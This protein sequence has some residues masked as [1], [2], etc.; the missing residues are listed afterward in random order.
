MTTKISWNTFNR[1]PHDSFW[2]EGL[3]G[4]RVLTH[5]ATTPSGRFDTYNAHLT[6]EEVL[7]TW[8]TYHDKM[9]NDEALMSYG[10]G[11]GGG[12]PTKEML[13]MARRMVD[14]PGM[15]RFRHDNPENLFDRLAEKAANTPDF[16][17]WVGELYLE[18]HRGTYTTQAKSKRANRKSEI[19]MHEAELFAATAN[20][21]LDAGYPQADFLEAWELILLNQFHD[22]L[23]GSSINKVYEDSMKQYAHVRELAESA[24]DSAQDALA[25]AVHVEGEAP[26]VVVFNG[27]GFGRTA[28]VEI[29]KPEGA[30]VL[31]DT[32]GESVPYQVTEGSVIFEADLPPVGWRTFRI[33]SAEAPTF[34]NPITVTGR[35]MENDFWKIAFDQAGQI[36][37]LYDKSAGREVIA[38]GAVANVFQAFE[39]KPL[40]N[41]AWEIEIFY[42]EKMWEASDPAEITIAETGPVRGAI[43]VVKH[44]ADSVIEQKIAIYAQNPRIDFETTVD[45]Q[46]SETLL[47]VAFPVDVLSTR[48]TYEVQFGAVERPTHWNTSWDWARFEVA[49]QKWA[50]LSEGGYG[51]ALLNDSKYGHDIRDNVM[52][53]TLLK[54]SLYPDPV[55]DRGLQRFTYALLPHVGDWREDRAGVVPA[56][57]DLN[58]PVEAVTRDPGAGDLP[59]AWSLVET[60]L[61]NVV[62][63]TVK[64]AEDTDELIVRLY[65][66]AG[67]RGKGVLK[68]GRPVKAADLC[69]LM[70]EERK[71]VVVKG[72]TVEYAVTPHQI[73][74]F[75]V[76]LK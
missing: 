43:K 49:G 5:F 31:R 36:T 14:L 58:Y 23:P 40:S 44:F 24:R 26:A 45:W 71:S 15:P 11:D 52:R 22:I 46:A 35:G 37:S 28:L 13:E 54:S 55:A 12:G 17:R 64:R 74:T 3:D 33:E 6:P 20:A 21:L 70:E 19:L 8:T 75:A 69:N 18:Y 57:Y 73:R 9:V 7:G 38:P 42:S 51:V 62:I 65:E 41:N 32:E 63:D 25:K 53:L 60:D 2:W 29:E 34:E 4:S 68:F 39:D 10:W 27:L 47:K 76:T 61:P 48:A 1:L 66:S 59:V 72:D 50:D 16:P 56:A 30:F 67:G